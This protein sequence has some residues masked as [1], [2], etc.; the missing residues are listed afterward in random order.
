LRYMNENLFNRAVVKYLKEE[1]EHNGFDVLLVAPTDAD[2][3]LE[4]RTALANAKKAD[5][6][7]SIHAN[8][9]SGNWGTWGGI[10]SF[11]YPNPESRRLTEILH[12]HVMKGTPFKNRG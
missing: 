8:A 2:T 9:I 3:P 7:I 5:I 10:E 4:T 12:K 11:Y 1:L 6:Y